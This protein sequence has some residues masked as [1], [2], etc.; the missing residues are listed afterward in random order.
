MLPT[1]TKPTREPDWDL[2]SDDAARDYVR[3]YAIGTKRYGE[4]LDC[5]DIG[6]SQPA[7]DKRRVEVKNAANCPEAGTTRDVF[8]VDVPGDRLTVDDKSKRK[9]LARWPDGSDPEGP[10]GSAREITSIRDWKSPLKDAV[11]GQLLVPIR[12]QTYG[13]GTYPVITIAGWHAAIV[14]GAGPD[15]LQAFAGTM[16]RASGGAPLGVFAGV[17]R[18]L[19]LRVR[20]PQSA[21]WDKL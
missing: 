14:P 1:G 13:R 6:P 16:C 7:G 5:A 18:S 10:P 12:M 20:C 17:D 2:D 15:A 3:R 4:T 9:P 8:L 21:R 11:Q 19:M